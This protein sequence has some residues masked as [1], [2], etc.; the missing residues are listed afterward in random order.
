MIMYKNVEH[1]V[2]TKQRSGRGMPHDEGWVM[3]V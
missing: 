2:R 1:W 3:A